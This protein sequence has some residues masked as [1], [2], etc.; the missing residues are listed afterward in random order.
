[1]AP[2][3]SAVAAHSFGYPPRAGGRMADLQ[4]CRPV[5]WRAVLM[6]DGVDLRPRL[7]VRLVDDG[8]GKA[9]EVV[10]A[11]AMVTVRA[12][13]LVLDEQIANPLELGEKCLG[14]RRLACSA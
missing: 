4:A 7:L 3:C 10:H 11:E 2:G 1:V 8:V 14:K 9:I 12:A 6:S 5:P 13:Q